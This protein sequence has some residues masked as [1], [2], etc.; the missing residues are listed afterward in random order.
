MLKELSLVRNRK[1]IMYVI[2]TRSCADC[3]AFMESWGQLPRV[4]LSSLTAQFLAVLVLDDYLLDMNP[5]L[6]PPNVDYL[7]RVFFADP[8]GTLR[9]EFTNE[10]GDRTVPFYYPKAQDVV[11]SMRRFLAQH[12]EAV[13]TDVFRA[14][15]EED[16]L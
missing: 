13:G 5:A 4:T 2:T 16:I 3:R 8:D 1:P 15:L 12:W 10:G 14:D 6:S 7:P 9:L 11:E